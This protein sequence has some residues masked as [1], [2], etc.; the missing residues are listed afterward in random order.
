[1]F[2]VFSDS[3]EQEYRIHSTNELVAL[4]PKN[5]AIRIKMYSKIIKLVN[6]SIS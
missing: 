3:L 4:D 2:I 6:R 1:M 5:T